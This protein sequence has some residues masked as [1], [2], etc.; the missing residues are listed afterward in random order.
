MVFIY[1]KFKA[2]VFIFTFILYRRK[3]IGINSEV[4]GKNKN[5]VGHVLFLYTHCT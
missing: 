2:M 5:Q 1:S 3:N 4:N